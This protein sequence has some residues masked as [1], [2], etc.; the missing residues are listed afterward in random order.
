M[1]STSALSA[2]TL[3]MAFGAL[4]P[5]LPVFAEGAKPAAAAP[6]SLPA[7][8][9]ST[10]GRQVL[11]DQIIASGLVSPVQQVN[12]A[13]LVEGQQIEELRADVG[14]TVQAGQVLARLS[15]SSLELQ[16]SQLNASFA[17]ARATIAQAQAQIAQAKSAADEAQRN[18]D[19]TIALKAV[20]NASQAAADKANAAAIFATAQL[21]VAIQSLE[22]TKAN[23]ALVEAQIANVD[24]QLARTEVTAPFGGEITARNATLGAIASA[25]GTPMFVLIRDGELELRADI[26]EADLLRVLPGQTAR[27]AFAASTPPLAG[28]VRLVEPT[29]DS[30]TRLGRVRISFD[31]STQVRAGMFV[32]ATILV[33]ERS[34]IAVPVTALG[35]YQDQPSVMLVE[36]GTA[37]RQIVATG[38]RDGGWVEVT[39]GLTE[40]QLVVTKAG[41]FVRDGDQINPIPEI[42]TN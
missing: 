24:L 12:V 13:P 23:L 32:E 5:A 16:K 10:V 1:R 37:R 29:I 39:E 20:G 2:L 25:A 21:V 27:L 35:S 17:A 26:A 14:D 4:A 33:V 9:V 19:R 6:S 36:N 15:R 8:T 40:G 38:I 18:N 28:T 22:A 34:G 30:A 31:D 7:I 3:T 41:A 42:S 11:R